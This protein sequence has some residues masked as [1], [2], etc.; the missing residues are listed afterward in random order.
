MARAVSEIGGVGHDVSE[1]R[2]KKMHGVVCGP[3]CLLGCAR[4]WAE[5][6]AAES[7]AR[8]T[9]LE[10]AAGGRPSWAEYRKGRNKIFFF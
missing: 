6:A 10:W 3:A 7:E 2:G 5:L 9:G 8:P 1:R 4:K